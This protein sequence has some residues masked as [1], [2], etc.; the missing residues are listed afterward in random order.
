MECNTGK[1]IN[2]GSLYS[3][4]QRLGDKR[5]PKG[6]RYALAVSYLGCIWQN[7]VEKISRAGLQ[8]GWCY[9]E[10]GSRVC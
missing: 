6:K 1:V 9:L 10:N 3:L 8:T 4:F 7:Y 2:L 5:K